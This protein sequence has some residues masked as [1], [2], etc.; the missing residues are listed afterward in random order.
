MGGYAVLRVWLR[1]LARRRSEASSFVAAELGGLALRMLGVLAAV[2]L[3]LA[4][5]PV[6]MGAFVGTVLV[7]LV[8]SIAVE[9]AL[10]VRRM[11]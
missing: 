3:V 7:L 4:F 10:I 1:R 5:V 2:G 11:G 8:L 9:T 6:H